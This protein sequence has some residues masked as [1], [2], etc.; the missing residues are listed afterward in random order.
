MRDLLRAAAARFG[1][2][3]ALL[4][5]GD[6]GWSPISFAALA[7][8]A[9]AVAG[10]LDLAPGERVAIFS[11]NRPEWIVAHF[12][13]AMAGGVTVPV[14]P[15][16]SAEEVGFVLRHAGVVRTLCG[17]AEQLSKVE[18]HAVDL[19]DLP[20]GRVG[21][22]ATGAPTDPY[23][24]V[25]TSGTTGPPKG[26]VLTHGAYR[27]G[28]DSVT[29]RGV[30][31][32]PDDLAY[33]YL[34][35]AHSFALL[36]LHAALDTGTPV[37]L[38]GG[39]PRRILAELAECRPTFLPSSPRLFEKV[40]RRFADSADAAQVRAAFGGRLRQAASGAAPIGADVL[41]FFWT[42]GI[43]VMEGYGMTETGRRR[44]RLHPGTPPLR[45]GGPGGA[46]VPPRHRGRR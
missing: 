27:A 18:R 45:H 34:P 9:E 11:A 25:Y 40:Y 37:A 7:G 13:V 22:P 42:C 1:D 39:D 17:D 19:A 24:M 28:I 15:G 41:R 3:P 31:R 14:Y 44:D 33:L 35:L 2:R 26:C 20:L 30:L 16:S 4:T 43:P 10:G 8:A 32:G 38:S 29:A 21:G 6:D 12:A 23:L 46:R 36:V 5:R